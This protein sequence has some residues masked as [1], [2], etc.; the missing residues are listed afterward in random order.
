MGLTQGEKVKCRHHLG[1]LGV[2]EVATFA[3]GVP[4]NVQTSFM[5]EPAMDL[6]LVE[7]EPLVRGFLEKLD[8]IDF[9]IFDDAETLVATKVGSIDLNQK[10]F[11]KLLERYDWLRGG[12]SNALGILP[13]PF[14]RRFYNPNGGGA[15]SINVPVMNG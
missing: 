8:A 10:E 14:D 11:E 5:I 4:A 12:L 15:G 7:T 13:N 9:Q 2:A 6:L 3:L 1:Y